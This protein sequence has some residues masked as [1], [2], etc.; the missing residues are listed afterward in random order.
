MRPQ[1]GFPQDDRAKEAERRWSELKEERTK[2]EPD[3]D[4]IARL[5]RPQR[6]GFRLDT[7]T[8]RQLS[9]SLSSEGAI[10]HGHFAAGIYSGITNPATR[11]GGFTTPDEELN[12]WAPFAEWLDGAA[13]KVHRS[14]SPSMSSFYPA[15]FQ[16]YGDLAAFGNGAG[17]DQVDLTNRKFIDVTFSLGEIVVAVDFHGRV[18]EAVRKL[19]LTPRQAIREFR[20]D[21]P[22]KI[23]DQAARGVVEKSVYYWHVLP[24]EAFEPYKLGPRGKRW[25]SRW[26]C[27]ADYTLMRERG[28]EEMPVYYPRWDVDSGMS[29]GTGPGSIALASARKLDVM[30][31]ATLRAA[32][33][34]ADPT[35]LAPDRNT[36]PL[37]GVFRPGST[38]YGAVSMQ[39][40]RLVQTEEFNGN[41]G[42]T[43]EEKR[44][45]AEA[46]ENAFYY[47]VM[48]LTGRT[49]ISDAEN[50]VIEEA[51]LRNWA[52]HADR[53][54]EE[55]AARK[56]ERRFR[57]LYRAG[58]IPPVPEGVPGGVPLMVSYTS[59]AAMALRASEA[60]AVRSLVLGDLLPL[61]QLKP[62]IL[63]R[64][65]ADDYAEVLHE[66]STAV[67]QRV[68]VPR[69][70]AAQ[71]REA[72]AQAQQAQSAVQMAAEGGA[73]MKELAQGMQAMQ[74][75]GEG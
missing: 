45:A 59:A 60:Q 28:Y 37:D 74:G 8:T 14:F 39:G 68:L 16:L 32:Q 67:P 27:A 25:L 69:E 22:A 38:V 35:K 73:G 40:H 57:M 66:A 24:N 9:K 58:Q 12:R 26:I 53:I 6:G 47:S 50:R 5:I 7:P 11:W 1:T 10:A 48:S 71:L 75:G 61:A 31:A 41:I 46:V 15:S 19:H 20:E 54:M 13:A 2:F 55:Y 30:E 17:Y 23:Q 63:D 34:A 42:L 43:L 44:A 62:E 18:C 72:R 56:Y 64:I 3:W 33:R 70:Q 29:Y 51:R 52:P 21:T 36:V 65:S 49:G 4:E